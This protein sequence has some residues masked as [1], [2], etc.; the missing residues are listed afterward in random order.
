MGNCK[1]CRSEV[2]GAGG[3]T[4]LGREA[5][6]HLAA[7]RDCR[8]FVRERAALRSLLAGLE[9]VSAPDDFDVRLRARMAKRRGGGRG[10]FVFNFSFAP[11]L[12]VAAAAV[13]VCAVAAALYVGRGRTGPEPVARQTETPSAPSV[14]SGAPA[15]SPAESPA[16]V[17]P[18]QDSKGDELASLSGAESKQPRVRRAPVA[19][20]SRAAESA[21]R[22]QARAEGRLAS[23]TFVVRS[24]P[25]FEIKMPVPVGGSAD[26]MRVVLKDENGSARV[27][28]V[29]SVSFGSQELIAR[30]PAGRRPAAANKEGV[31]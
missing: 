31:W 26:S 4:P 8:D 23:N 7:C 22:S 10:R 29:R 19:R 11:A 20:A 2:E 30:G 24:A 18:E 5:E 6:S 21:G 27:V 14:P 16:A 1:A 28:P 3:R 17:V 12:S 25:V 15:S 13:L 9:R